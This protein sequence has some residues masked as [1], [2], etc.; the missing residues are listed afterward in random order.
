MLAPDFGCVLFT[1]T[2]LAGLS[3]FPAVLP[4]VQVWAGSANLFVPPPHVGLASA[5]IVAALMFFVVF[6]HEQS[7]CSK[8]LDRCPKGREKEF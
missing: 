2:A 3:I 1:A 4:A 6:A 8:C 7:R 5:G